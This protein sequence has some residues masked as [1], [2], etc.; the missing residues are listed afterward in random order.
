M[1]QD[2]IS[3]IFDGIFFILIGLFLLVSSVLDAY[4]VFQDIGLVAAIVD[5][6]PGL[7]WSAGAFLLGYVL[8]HLSSKAKQPLVFDRHS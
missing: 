3:A 4:A 5:F 6:L 2:Y 1:S 8:Y 7:G